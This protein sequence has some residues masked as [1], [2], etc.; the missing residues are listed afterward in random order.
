MKLEAALIISFVFLLVAVFAKSC[1]D[2]K[3]KAKV[4]VYQPYLEAHAQA[5]R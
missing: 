3:P 1:T 2:E 5:R 4:S